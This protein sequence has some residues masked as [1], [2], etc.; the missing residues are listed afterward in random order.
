MQ[1]LFNIFVC[2]IPEDGPG[3]P[4]H[5][6]KEYKYSDEYSCEQR[7]IISLLIEYE[8]SLKQSH[9]QLLLSIYF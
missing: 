7:Y 9:H 5:V 8:L 4:K 3:G 1:Q 2:V 6:V